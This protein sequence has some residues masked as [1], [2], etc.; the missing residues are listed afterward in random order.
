VVTG[1]TRL[2]AGSWPAALGGT[3]NDRTAPVP[4]TGELQVR[5]RVDLP[6]EQ[7]GA[8]RVAA[9]GALIVL[10]EDRITALDGPVVRWSV[11]TDGPAYLWF[12]LDNGLFVT[13]EAGNL[14]VREQRTGA[15]TA[16]IAVSHFSHPTLLP[17]GLVAFVD[18]QYGSPVLCA[19]TL[20]GQRRW[21]R[22]LQSRWPDAPLLV[23]SNQVIVADGANLRSF[24]AEGAPEWTVTVETATLPRTSA[25]PAPVGAEPPP[26]ELGPLLMG[27]P[28]G[29][30]LVNFE[31][32]DRHG[33]LVV[34]PHTAEVRA[35]PAHLPIRG[36]AVP[37]R[38]GEPQRELVV[39]HGWS[40]KD[41]YSQFRPT[42]TV[43]DVNTGATVFQHVVAAE[44]HS[45]VAGST[46]TVAVAG[47]PSWERWTKYK[48]AQDFYPIADWYYV[49][50]FDSSEIRGEW[51]PGEPI[52]GSLAVG[53]DGDLL[54]PLQGALVSLGG[55]AAG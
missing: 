55:P 32:D 30:I 40:E 21:E 16:T 34:D 11:R 9:D 54:V 36:M 3:A 5:W 37:L 52:T 7:V 41:D 38:N 13:Q 14:V 53:P 50:L 28:S 23:W 49:L 4:L 17:N 42:V 29:P 18:G 33:Y 2:D 48:W 39:L 15:S 51:R 35:L 24:T 10:A 46:G 26:G 20:T 19:A 1:R 12:L 22:R 8:V 43:V 31:A 27:L 45:M 25:V 44:P 47:G 6:H